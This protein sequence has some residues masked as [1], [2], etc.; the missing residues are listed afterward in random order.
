MATRAIQRCFSDTVAIHASRHGQIGFFCEPIALRNSAMTA[1]TSN[2]GVGVDRVAEVHPAWNLINAY[3]RHFLV[4]GGI[5]FQSQDAGCVS[6]DRTMANHALRDGRERHHLTGI[7]RSVAIGAFQ[8]E[9]NVL[10][11]AKRDWLGRRLGRVRKSSSYEYNKRGEC[12]FQISLV[13][14]LSA[15]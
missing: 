2:T 8:A 5:L 4:C 14:I 11:V 3:P 1:I 12:A 6:F 9:G 15:I 10:F 7:G 13:R